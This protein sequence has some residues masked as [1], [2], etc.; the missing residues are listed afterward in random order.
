MKKGLIFGLIL[1]VIFGAQGLFAKDRYSELS[2]PILPIATLAAA[3]S[4]DAPIPNSIRNNRYFVESVRYT[5]LAQEAFE[6]GDYD[7]STQYSTEAVR[8]AQL[9][10]EYVM[11]QLK[12]RE[13]DLAIGTARSRL[14][15]AASS[16][17]N[18]Q[19]RYPSEYRDAQNTFIQAGVYRSS[20]KWDDAI[21]S[22]NRVINLLAFLTEIPTPSPI[23]GTAPP[24]TYPLPAQYTVRPWS[25]SKDCLW[26]ISGRPWVYNDPTQWRL[27]YNANKAK[28]PQP[29]NPDLIHP[30][31]IL[32]I[33]SIRGEV[34][35]GMWDPSRNYSPLR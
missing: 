22:A 23:P 5:N 19:T 24:E 29:D 26:N 9:S 14:D 11:L 6:E 7:T 32:D 21:S 28:M 10:D 13:T 4:P 17:V 16:A 2:E 31:M 34:R 35:Q 20:E 1:T 8:Y 30:D 15:W 12:I 33:P 3:A 27:L 25:I 18:A